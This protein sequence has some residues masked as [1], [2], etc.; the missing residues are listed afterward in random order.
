MVTAY[1]RRF[2]GVFGAKTWDLIW[3]EAVHL[4]GG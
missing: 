2:S 4:D 3:E 1:D